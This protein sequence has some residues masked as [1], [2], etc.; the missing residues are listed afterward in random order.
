MTLKWMPGLPMIVLVFL[1]A[2][3]MRDD[4]PANAAPH[5]AMHRIAM[6]D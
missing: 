4:P 5:E 3:L 6:S 2:F 1:T